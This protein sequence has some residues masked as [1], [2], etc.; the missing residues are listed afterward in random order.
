MYEGA[1]INVWNE[2]YEVGLLD[3]NTV[4]KQKVTVPTDKRQFYPEKFER[5]KLF[6]GMKYNLLKTFIKI[7]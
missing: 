4:G 2:E 3:W 7:Y 6:K 1:F 5:R